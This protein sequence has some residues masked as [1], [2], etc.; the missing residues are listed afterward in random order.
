MPDENFGNKPSQSP[1]HSFEREGFKMAWDVEFRKML[2]ENPGIIKNAI[3]LMNQA[4]QEYNPQ[5]IKLG[6]L[7][8]SYDKKSEKWMQDNGESAIDYGRGT[9]F[10]LDKIYK[11]EKSGLEI[12]MLGRSKRELESGNSVRIDDCDYFKINFK[13]NSYFVKRSFISINP[14]FNEFKNTISANEALKDLDFVKIVDARLG[15]QDE[16]ESWY[17][18]RW[19]DIEQAGFVSFD[20]LALGGVDDYGNLIEGFLNNNYRSETNNMRYKE[21]TGKVSQIRNRLARAG[22]NTEDLYANL[23]CN[24]NTGTFILLDVGVDEKGLGNPIR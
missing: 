14:G 22:I 24:F 18:S 15:F 13:D 21:L 23:F 3:E 4:T 17:V 16:K 5:P 10:S 6:D 7:E 9:F 8:V 19:Q 11:D 12:S 1:I 2:R 20:T